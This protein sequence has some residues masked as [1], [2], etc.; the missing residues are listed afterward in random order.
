M[1]DLWGF[2]P[3]FKRAGPPSRIKIEDLLETPWDNPLK[4]TSNFVYKSKE[5][6]LD[7]SGIAKGYAVDLIVEFLE[8]KGL[9]IFL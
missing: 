5:T 2:G 4:I 6:Q 7:F 8:A 9:K 3:D 1:V